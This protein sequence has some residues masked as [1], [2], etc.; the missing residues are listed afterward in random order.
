M[1]SLKFPV[2]QNVM[3]ILWNS[4]VIPLKTLASCNYRIPSQSAEQVCG[5]MG[6]SLTRCRQGY[7]VIFSFLSRGFCCTAQD[8]GYQQSFSPFLE[9]LSKQGGTLPSSSLVAVVVFPILQWNRNS[10]GHDRIYWD[11]KT[12]EIFMNQVFCDIL[13]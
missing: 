2:S 11:F 3:E 13:C 8:G 9:E 4:T 7:W 1:Y 12:N 6:Q 10:N 5:G